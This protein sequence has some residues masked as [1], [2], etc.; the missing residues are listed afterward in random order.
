MR[1]AVLTIML[2]LAWLPAEAETQIAAAGPAGGDAGTASMADGEPVG[3]APLDAAG[4]DLDE[5]LWVKRPVVVFADTPADPRFRQ[6]MAFFADRWPELEA[7][8]VIVIT[9]TD[10]EAES[11]VRRTL[12]PRGFMLAILDK[13]GTVALRKPAPWDVREI[14]RTIDKMPSRREETR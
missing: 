7:R 9:D 10:P 4:I 11:S 12:R 1:Y 3:F 6:Q 2:A 13:D 5:F 14:S 8:D